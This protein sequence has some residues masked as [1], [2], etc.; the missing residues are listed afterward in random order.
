MADLVQFR[1]K[2][3]RILSIVK[4]KAGGVK[5]L[6]VADR[7]YDSEPKLLSVASCEQLSVVEW[8]PMEAHPAVSLACSPSGGDTASSS[9]LPWLWSHN[10]LGAC[11]A[12][13]N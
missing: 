13:E 2:L 9:W 5:L 11:F 1:R 8:L 12:H 10:G 7:M 3:F 6:S 4:D